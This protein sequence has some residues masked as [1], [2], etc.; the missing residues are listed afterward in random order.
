MA[1]SID[2]ERRL[3]RIRLVWLLPLVLAAI[4]ASVVF[5]TSPQPPTIYRALI[6]V[7]PPTTALDSAAAVNLFITDLGQ[8]AESDLISL[9]L[10]DQIPDLNRDEY[11]RDLSVEREGATSWVA[12][13]FV[14]SDREVARATV[15]T[16]ALRLLDDAARQDVDR[17]SFLLD[18]A[19][20]R[21]TEAQMAL[22]E[23]AATESVFDPEVEYRILLDEISRLDAEIVAAGQDPEVDETFV[24]SLVFERNRLMAGRAGLGEALLTFNRLSADVGNAQN[25]FQKARADN[26][27]AVFE[28]EGVNAPQN[29]VGIRE[30]TPFIDNAARIQRSALAGAV[31][32]VLALVIVLPMAWFLEKRHVQGRHIDLIT[33]SLH[34]SAIR[35][36]QT[37]TETDDRLSGLLERR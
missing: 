7:R 29:L 32:L 36:T 25:A 23:F 5:L 1:D 11:P 20:Q 37:P 19:A 12:I 21:L 33:E 30:L 6:T 17:T 35:Q 22:D 10:L 14:H 24:D 26:E 4:A 16:L 9:F 27:A 28:Y 13:S 15:E 2:S 8:Q 18:K 3:K 34:D 31:A